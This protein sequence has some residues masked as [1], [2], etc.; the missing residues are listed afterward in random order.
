MLKHG[1]LRATLLKNL[2]KQKQKSCYNTVPL[3]NLQTLENKL[4]I[5]KQPTK[6]Q[7]ILLQHLLNNVNFYMQYIFNVSS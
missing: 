5:R 7:T 6:K 1:M 3:V 2:N 4:R